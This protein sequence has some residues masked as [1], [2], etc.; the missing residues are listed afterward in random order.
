MLLLAIWPMH[1]IC[2]YA[3]VRI[4]EF[5]AFSWTRG[6]ITRNWSSICHQ[7][8]NVCKP[9]RNTI[10][11]LIRDFDEYESWMRGCDDSVVSLWLPCCNLAAWLLKQGRHGRIDELQSV[12]PYLPTNV[13]VVQVETWTTLVAELCVRPSDHLI[14]SA[15]HQFCLQQQNYNVETK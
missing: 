1:G 6:P 7:Q 12:G 5:E 2:L 15:V 13:L 4:T 14:S 9:T 3:A 8:A 10:I 11:G